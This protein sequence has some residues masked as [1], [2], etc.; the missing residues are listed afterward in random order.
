LYDVV[1]PG[2]GQYEA[3]I[4][5]KK[6]R[7]Y[8]RFDKYSTYNRKQYFIL[9]PVSD[10][11]HTAEFKVSAEKLDKE[12]ILGDAYL[13]LKDKSVLEESACYAASV[14]VIGKILQ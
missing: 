13:K 5:G 3:Y 4:D 8:P 1:G 14:L 7:D 9:P 10:G 11:I 2:G 6:V 12:K